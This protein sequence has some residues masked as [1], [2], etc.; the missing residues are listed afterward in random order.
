MISPE[1][2]GLTP[3]NS[4]QR[5]DYTGNFI[6][7]ID[8]SAELEAMAK[9]PTIFPNST[10][11]YVDGKI[12]SSVRVPMRQIRLSD[13]EH[14]ASSRFPE[15]RVEK[16]PPINVYDC[17][18]PWGDPTFEGDVRDGLPALRRDWILALGD[19]EEY[20]GRETKPADNG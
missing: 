2:N 7:D 15:G 10:R 16:N 14:P 6:E 11:V 19:V 18:G 20:E 17:S 12:H 3:E 9:D 1:H 13:T 4:K 5:Q 8:N